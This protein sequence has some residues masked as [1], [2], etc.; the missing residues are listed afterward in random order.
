MPDLEAQI[1]QQ[2]E[3]EFDHLFAARRALVG[4]QEQE[5]DV[6]L[7]R[8]LGAAIAAHRHQRQ[9]LGRGRIGDGIDVP[10]GIVMDQPHDL[11]DQEAERM[12]GGRPAGLAAVQPL[13]DLGAAGGQRFL[14]GVAQL[15]L[16]RLAVQRAILRHGVEARIERPPVDDLA[17]IGDLVHRLAHPQPRAAGA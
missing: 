11:V 10:V 15:G 12:D 14:Q 17:L 1:P 5:I 2:V 13:A 8:Q 6:R 7:R 4:Q 3:D 16:A 9:A